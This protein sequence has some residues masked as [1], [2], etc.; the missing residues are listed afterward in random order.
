MAK[1]SLREGR[2]IVFADGEVRTIYP[3][4]IRQLRV[5]MKTVKDLQDEDKPKIEGED[6]DLMVQ[7]ASIALEKVDPELAHDLDGLEDVLDIKI[8]NELLAAAMGTDP[9]A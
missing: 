8:F 5:F 3:L 9:N 6:I 4:T 1:K 2:D 7:A